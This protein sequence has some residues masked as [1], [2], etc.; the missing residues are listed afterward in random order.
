MTDATDCMTCSE[1]PE[2]EEYPLNECPRSERHCG[3]HCNC[4]WVHD[5]CHWCDAEFVD[6]DEHEGVSRG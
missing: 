4:S 6:A 5:H 3:H 1:D 2:H